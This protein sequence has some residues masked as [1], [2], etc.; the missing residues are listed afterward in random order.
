MARDF[1]LHARCDRT[2]SR[3]IPFDSGRRRINEVRPISVADPG[4]EVSWPGFWPRSLASA[5]P[6]LL[7]AAALL[8]T[9]YPVFKSKRIIQQPRPETVSQPSFRVAPR[10]KPSPIPSASTARP[11]DLF[12]PAQPSH[13]DSSLPGLAAVH[14]HR[15]RFEA[16]HKKAFGGCTGQ[17]ELTSAALHFTCSHQADLDL[18][19]GSIAS[20]DKDGVLLGSGEKYHFLIADHTKVQVETIFNQWLTSARQPRLA[21]RESS[22]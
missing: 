8:G 7:L 14:D 6:V 18:P 21:S 19:I 2:P 12:K 20:T 4:S 5:G 13:T 15:L 1:D 10:S 17:L 3:T 11:A 22:F 16:T 9:L